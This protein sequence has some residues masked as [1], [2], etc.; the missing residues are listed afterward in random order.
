MPSVAKNTLYLTS[1]LVGQK[2]LSFIYFT[3]IARFLGA[4]TVGK[5][6]FA[7]AFTT[8]FAIIAELGLTPV[9]VREI[10]R[11]KSRAQEYLSTVLGIKCILAFVA[12]SAV[13]LGAYSLGHPR[14]TLELIALAGVVMILDT[15]HFTLYGVLRGLQTL[16]YEA[17]GMVIG[18]VMTLAAGTVALLLKMPLH[19]FLIAMGIGS[20]FNVVIA[21]IVL[22]RHGIAAI[23]KISPKLARTVIGYAIPFALAG[24]F[25]RVYSYIDTVLLQHLRGD[26]EVGWYSV[27]YKITYA[28]QFFPMAL[29]AAIYP[30]LA[31]TW[32]S[33]R[34][35]T[36]WIF[37]H[38][39]L[40]CI[41]LSLPISLGIFA[42]A[43]EIIM[44]VYGA[45]FV[46]S[47]LP[48][49]I[50]I[51]GLLF[52]FLYF[53]V[54]A[55]LNATNNQSV[56]TALMGITMFANI[57]ANLILIPRFGAVGASIAAVSTNAFLW[58]TTLIWALRILKPSAS[59]ARVFFKAFFAV[60]VMTYLV[61]TIKTRIPWPLSIPLGGIVY[62][63]L[64]FA[65][66][67]I[68]PEDIRMFATL[69]RK[70]P[71]D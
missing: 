40:Y 70:E 22:Q 65:L 39:L 23:P 24:I 53:P 47:I 36:R 6:T 45:E 18:Q 31:N 15:I 68:S 66:R 38:A 19:A 51:F 56:N 1:A 48:L 57:I 25:V 60:A 26:I 13:I 55:L 50:S 41:L 62:A 20:F 5:Y 44:T 7:I 37:D 52:I 16:Q 27:P 67:A 35:R 71:I 58:I 54:G 63:G 69:F 14:L 59:A 34:A 42:L 12:Y 2:L 21:F 32:I 43:P 11:A 49:Q 28:F 29:S 4:E 30:A 33:D 3:L 61:L 8:I 17:V 64:L 46:N 9:L 10:A